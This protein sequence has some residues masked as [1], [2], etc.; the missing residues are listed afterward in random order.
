MPAKTLIKS[1]EQTQRKKDLKCETTNEMY[2]YTLHM[3]FLLTCL[4]SLRHVF[5]LVLSSF[6]CCLQE[7][8]LVFD[9]YFISFIVLLIYYTLPY[10]RP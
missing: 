2:Y 1:R 4:D 7:F 9:K 8:S 6:V 3:S 5:K 10:L